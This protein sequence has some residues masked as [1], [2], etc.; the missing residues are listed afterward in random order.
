[1]ALA[2]AA[3]VMVS[4]AGVVVG[5][6]SIALVT[7]TTAA[8]LAL[9]PGLDG[10]RVRCSKPSGTRGTPPDRRPQGLAF[11]VNLV[12]L[13]HVWV[14]L[15]FSVSDWVLLVSAGLPVVVTMMLVRKWSWP[16]TYLGW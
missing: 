9:R 5:A 3:I 12:S 16:G 11:V 6:M 8:G 13:G 10:P 14:I 2:A 15:T 1:M 7:A 4:T